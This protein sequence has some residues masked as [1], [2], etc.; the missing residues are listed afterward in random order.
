MANWQIGAGLNHETIYYGNTRLMLNL[1]A[2]AELKYEVSEGWFFLLKGLAVLQDVPN[3]V[4]YYTFNRGMEA[5]EDLH[6]VSLL[7]IAAN[8]GRK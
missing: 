3:I 2:G 5:G 6:F 8:I 1:V 7:G 4:R